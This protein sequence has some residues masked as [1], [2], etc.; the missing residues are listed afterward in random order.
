MT[1]TC[2]A[3][4]FTDSPAR[5]SAASD[6]PP[7]CRRAIARKKEFDNSHKNGEIRAAPD[8][9]AIQWPTRAGRGDESRQVRP[10]R[11]ATK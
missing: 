7:A 9:G 8:T 6:A 3:K 4:I 1:A 2:S 11:Q 5:Q 10:A